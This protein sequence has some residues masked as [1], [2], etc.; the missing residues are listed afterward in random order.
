MTLSGVEPFAFY[1]S[2][3]TKGATAYPLNA[4]YRDQ[5]SWRYVAG[6][7]RESLQTDQSGSAVYGLYCCLLPTDIVGSNTAREMDVYLRICRDLVTDLISAR[8]VVRMFINNV[9]NPGQPED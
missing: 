6:W 2:V 1:C 5:I 9:K 4:K 3:S 8:G 7:G